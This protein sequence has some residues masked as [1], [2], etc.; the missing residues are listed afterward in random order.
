MTKAYAVKVKTD[1]KTWDIPCANLSTLKDEF[2]KICNILMD[3]SIIMS[4]D[5][6]NDMIDTFNCNAYKVVNGNTE[7]ISYDMAL[8]NGIIN[9]KIYNISKYYQYIK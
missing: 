3:N 4:D 2:T 7:Y 1:I 6:K 8:K 9:I 5:I